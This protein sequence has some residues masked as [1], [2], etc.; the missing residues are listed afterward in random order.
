[1]SQRRYAALS[2]TRSSD[3]RALQLVSDVRPGMVPGD[4]SS[5][6]ISWRAPGVRFPDNE[7]GRSQGPA[8]LSALNRLE[9]APAEPHPWVVVLPLPDP[10]L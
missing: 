7:Y 4:R 5:C 9:A 2:H 3:L 8:H 10:L 6:G 1:M